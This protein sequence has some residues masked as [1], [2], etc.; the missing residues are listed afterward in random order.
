LGV[1]AAELVFWSWLTALGRFFLV[2]WS[3]SVLGFY[4]FPQVVQCAG[5]AFV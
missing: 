5:Q 2:G 3:C 1:V 4:G